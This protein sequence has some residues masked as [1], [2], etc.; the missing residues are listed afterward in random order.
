ME[1]RRQTVEL[2]DAQKV[3]IDI[4]FGAGNLF[5]GGSAEELLEAKY[6]C[7]LNSPNPKVSYRYSKEKGRLS[8][9]QG[10][11]AGL[12]FGAENWDLRFNSKVP[13]TMNIRCGAGESLF[14]ISELNIQKL[15][16]KY[17]AG[18]IKVDLR[19]NWDHD[20]DVW[21][22]GG[23]GSSK[24]KL[25]DEMKIEA[26]VSTGLGSTVVNGLDR[27]LGK[28]TSGDDKQNK[29]T[30]YVKGG[31]GEVKLLKEE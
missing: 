1:V 26:V 11:C 21:V 9:R 15:N 23:V 5:I 12:P 14:R 3:E 24:F 4:A 2:K 6:R 29:L 22:E 13:I 17:G 25:P 19:H 28:Y 27:H 31:I 30:L 8:V 18:E 16:L 20:V 10:N 7:Y